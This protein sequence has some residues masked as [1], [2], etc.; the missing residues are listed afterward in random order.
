V[1]AVQLTFTHKQY[2][3]THKQYTVCW[4]YIDYEGCL[5]HMSTLVP[6]FTASHPR[7]QEVLVSLSF[8]FSLNGYV[9]I[10]SFNHL[11]PLSNVQK[12]F[13]QLYLTQNCGLP[14]CRALHLVDGTDFSRELGASIF[15]V[16]TNLWSHSQTPLSRTCV[17]SLQTS[18]CYCD[19]FLTVLRT[20]CYLSRS[21]N[22]C[23]HYIFWK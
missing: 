14:G 17:S 19:W 2:T 20:I 8:I 21:I 5:R 12:R 10:C 11:L 9:S 3:E 22:F 23:V 7:R 1:A 18:Y 13:S 4:I 16:D 6:N 15:R